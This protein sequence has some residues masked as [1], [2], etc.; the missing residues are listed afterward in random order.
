MSATVLIVTDVFGNTPAIASLQR[1]LCL[2]CDIVSPFAEGYSATT[3]QTAYQAFLASGGVQ[4]YAKKIESIIQQNPFYRHVIGFSAGASA[5]W[6]ANTFSA[7][8]IDSVT[9]FYGSRIRDHVDH[10]SSQQARGNTHLIFAEKENA[11][12]PQQVVKALHQRGYHAEIASGTKHGFMNP[13][14][15]GFS[16]KAQTHYMELLVQ[17]LHD[18][19]ALAFGT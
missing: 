4:T 11:Y 14:A 15:A 16:L 1:H 19:P 7:T 9:L 6:L 10:N 2:P 3:E 8:K 12:Q 5:W 17:K 13:Y 18:H